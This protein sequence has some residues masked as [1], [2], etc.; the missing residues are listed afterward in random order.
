MAPELHV[1]ASHGVRFHSNAKFT[2]TRDFNADDVPLSPRTT[3]WPI[4]NHPFAKVTPGQTYGVLRRHMGM[5]DIV[6]RV[7]KVDPMTVRF[8]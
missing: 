2:P 1:Q 8:S 6:E 3:G 5:K 7:E 4:S